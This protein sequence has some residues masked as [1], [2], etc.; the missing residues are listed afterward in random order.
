MPAKIQDNIRFL[1]SIP[2]EKIKVEINKNI[3]IAIP[4]NLKR[5]AIDAKN[6]AKNQK[7][8]LIK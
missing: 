2:F 6:N 7:S 5:T 1:L 8:F 4:D 3:T